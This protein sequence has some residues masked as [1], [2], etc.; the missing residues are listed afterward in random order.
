[1]EDDPVVAAWSAIMAQQ[2][3]LFSL[4]D[5]LVENN[6]L[7]PREAA[8]MLRDAAATLPEPAERPTPGALLRRVIEGAA[9]RIERVV[10]WPMDKARRV[11]RSRFWLR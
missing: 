6:A 4:I 11:E 7:A 8:Q 2:Q 3:M 10:T 5:A 1:M 9:T